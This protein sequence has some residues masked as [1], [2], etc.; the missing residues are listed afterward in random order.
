[1]LGRFLLLIMHISLDC[2]LRHLCIV[3]TLKNSVSLPKVRGLFLRLKCRWSRTLLSQIRALVSLWLT[4]YVWILVVQYRLH[5]CSWRYEFNHDNIPLIS[6]IH[7][8]PFLYDLSA[9]SQPFLTWSIYVSWF[10]MSWNSSFSRYPTSISPLNFWSRNLFPCTRL[11]I[12]MFRSSR[13]SI[14]TVIS[15]YNLEQIVRPE[16]PWCN[17]T[18]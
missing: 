15:R 9:I 18:S 5:D 16:D 1:M 14:F 12:S 10:P 8:H 3:S 4:L 13:N 7:D 2:K 11:Y 6:V 17:S